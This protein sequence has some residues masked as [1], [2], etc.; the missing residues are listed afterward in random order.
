[1][2]NDRNMQKDKLPISFVIITYDEEKNIRDCLESVKGWVDEIFIVDSYSADKTLEIAR[3]Y[4][5]K[6]YQHPFENY[7]LLIAE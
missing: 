7:S 6:I 3:K 5:D 4:T 2:N 1:M